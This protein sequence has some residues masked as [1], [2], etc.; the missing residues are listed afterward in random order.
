MTVRWNSVIP[1]GA[2]HALASILVFADVNPPDSANQFLR[3][4]CRSRLAYNPWRY[5]PIPESGA[6][7]D[8]VDPV[9]IPM[10]NPEPAV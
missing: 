8:E 5:W 9:K 4:A 1:S 3:V 7:F 10:A 2:A 6:T